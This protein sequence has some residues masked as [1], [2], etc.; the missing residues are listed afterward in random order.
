MWQVQLQELNRQSELL[1]EKH[2]GDT[3]ESVAA[4]TDELIDRFRALFLKAEQRGF[5]L[6]QASDYFDFLVRARAVSEW[7]AQTSAAIRERPSNMDLF[8]VDQQKQ[9]HDS[10][11][12]EMSQRDADFKG[13][14]FKKLK[15]FFSPK[16]FFSKIARFWSYW[17]VLLFYAS[18]SKFLIYSQN[19]L[20]RTNREFQMSCPD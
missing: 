12:F 13:G 4:E 15:K 3:A 11:R 1:R 8:T 19:S 2:P 20:I 18:R 17:V 14:W 10:L 7:M 5:E 9:E 6:K 16:E